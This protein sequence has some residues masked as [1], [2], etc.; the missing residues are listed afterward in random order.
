MQALANPEK[1]SAN[2]EDEQDQPN[3]VGKVSFYS[4]SYS[5]AGLIL[6]LNGSALQGT[7]CGPGVRHPGY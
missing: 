2:S 1:G 4:P 5:Y 7:E 6:A 3:E